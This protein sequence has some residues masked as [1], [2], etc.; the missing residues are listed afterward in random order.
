MMRSSMPS[1]LTSPAPLTEEPDQS[2]A[3]DAVEREAV[4][5]VERRRELILLKKLSTQTWWTSLGC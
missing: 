5:A 4:A 3:I 1:P 2:Y